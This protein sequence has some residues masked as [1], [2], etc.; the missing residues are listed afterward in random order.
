MI[1]TVTA[2]LGAGF[3]DHD[4]GASHRI[5]GQQNG[6]SG[7]VEGRFLQ[8]MM[9]RRER[10]RGALAMHPAQ[11]IVHR[12]LTRDVVADEVH[13]LAVHARNDFLKGFEH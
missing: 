13:Q 9:E 8:C 10:A 4:D 11:L 7:C 12:F 6:M 1:H 3:G 2:F 5:S